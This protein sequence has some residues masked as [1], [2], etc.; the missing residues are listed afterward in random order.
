MMTA[1]VA[2]TVGALLERYDFYIVA[3]ASVLV[4]GQLF[5]SPA[6]GTAG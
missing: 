3:T 4:F 5:A 1:A 2:G 6:V